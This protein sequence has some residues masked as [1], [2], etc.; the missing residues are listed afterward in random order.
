MYVN[1]IK[2][3]FKHT[4]YYYSINSTLFSH[5]PAIHN[6]GVINPRKGFKDV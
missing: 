4:I 5:L 2:K 3:L 1:F 6:H